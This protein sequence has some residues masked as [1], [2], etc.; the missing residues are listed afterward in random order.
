MSNSVTLSTG[1]VVHLR[2]TYT[3]KADREFNRAI[4]QG[5]TWVED[6]ETGKYKPSHQP[7]E[8]FAL[9]VEASLLCL[10]LRVTDATGA[11]VAPSQAWLDDLKQ[12]DYE[13]LAESEA[14]M[15]QGVDKEKGKKNS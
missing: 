13:R 8:N 9:A 3:H 6:P 4:N 12:Q 5:V 1:E 10:I 15:R 7:L 14:A 2:D 11:E